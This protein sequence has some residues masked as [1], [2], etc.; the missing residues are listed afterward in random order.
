[1]R[2]A[3]GLI[4]KSPRVL[5][6]LYHSGI[7]PK[8]RPIVVI[9]NFLRPTEFR[10]SSGTTPTL[11]FSDAGN[12][13][14][15]TED[16]ADGSSESTTMAKNSSLRNSSFLDN[17]ST[18]FPS[19]NDTGED[20]GLNGEIHQYFDPAA[21]IPAIVQALLILTVNGLV[22]LLMAKKKYLRSITNLLLCSLATSDLLT[23]LVAVPMFI[24]CNIIRQS[25]VCLAEEEMSRFISVSIVCHLMAVT[26]DRYLAII[27]PLHYSSLVTKSRCILV[28]VLIWLL[29]A[30]ASLV[31]L[32]WLVPVSQDPHDPDFSADFMKKEF[33]YDIIFLT[34]FFFL[35]VAFMFYTYVRIT[36]AIARQSRNIRLQNISVPH[37]GRIRGRHEWKAVGIF[38]AMM[39]VYIICWLPYAGLRRFD[40]NKLPI[41]LIYVILYLRYLASLLNPCMYIFGKQDFRKAIFENIPVRPLALELSFTSTSKSAILK[42]TL[43][44]P[45]GK[46]RM[47]S[48]ARVGSRKIRN[49]CRT[50]A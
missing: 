24:T 9:I 35:P 11:F 32:T 4:R 42:A 25:A 43:A 6:V 41:T 40:L 28:I 21:D 34:L 50:V 14:K 23:G 36:F 13:S 45:G 5:Q 12:S 33:I 16:F 2:E 15:L 46:V 3:Q 7:S 19:P 26:T 44:T 31:Q 10:F 38:A 47:K 29:S 39:L 22:L 30:V 20:D 27:H 37:S 48:F 18:G 17:N 1:L 49:N 8:Q